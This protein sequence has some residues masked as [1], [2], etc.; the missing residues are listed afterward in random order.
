MFGTCC[1]LSVLAALA[2]PCP[3]GT[4]PLSPPSERGVALGLF[5]ADPRYDY[6]ELVEE[7]A[8]LGATHLSVVWVHW[9]DDVRATEIGPRPGMSAT[10]SQIVETM[11]QAKAAGLHVTGFPIVRLLHGG[12][13]DWRGKIAPRDEDAWWESYRAFI[14]EGALLAKEGGADRYSVGSELLSRESM[15]SRWLDL[16]DRVR[17]RAEKLEL[18]YSANWDHYRPVTFWDAVDVIGLTAYWE[19]TR[20]HDASTEALAAAWEAP[21]AELARWS[22]ALGRPV[23]F[24]EIGYPSLDGGAAWP[25]DETRRADVD[26]EEQARAYRA[27]RRAWSGRDL[28]AGVYFWNWFGFGGP[29]DGNYTPRGKPA[30]EVLRSWYGE[31]TNGECSPSRLRP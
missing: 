18:L 27:F 2:A 7:I 25:W 24:T 23:V 16:I 26:L 30:E 22:E 20:S 17:L 21:R 4:R 19:L 31:S 9:Q 12:H 3:D 10:R 6:R 1:S 15:R 8:Q 28:L 11:A 13:T 5:S 29:K 14:L